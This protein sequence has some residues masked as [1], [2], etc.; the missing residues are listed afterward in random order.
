MFLGVLVGDSVYSAAEV[1]V[2]DGVGVRVAV[3]SGV[4]VGVFG[5]RSRQISGSGVC[6]VD[7]GSEAPIEVESGVEVT[8]AVGE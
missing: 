7:V 1:G 2:K 4:L 3:G 8:V 5:E 6:A